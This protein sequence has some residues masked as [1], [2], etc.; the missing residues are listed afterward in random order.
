MT[1]TNPSATIIYDPISNELLDNSDSSL[2]TSQIADHFSDKYKKQAIDLAVSNLNKAK[3]ANEETY[4]RIQKAA[5]HVFKVLT[6]KQQE[7]DKKVAIK[8]AILEDLL[9]KYEQHNFSTKEALLFIG[10]KGDIPAILDKEGHI[11]PDRVNVQQALSQPN[12]GT[13]KDR[14][15]ESLS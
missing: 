10:Q 5:D 8:K 4:K 12:D 3:K 9:N 14:K 2:T 7:S 6:Q 11:N 15:A 1:T 13:N